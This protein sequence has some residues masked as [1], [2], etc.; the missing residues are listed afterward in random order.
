MP[1]KR[2]KSKLKKDDLIQKVIEM[3]LVECKSTRNILKYLEGIGLKS[4][5]QYQYL[6]WAREQI[7]E[8]FDATTPEAIN[9][10]IGQYESVMEE[11]LKEKNYRMW[12]DMNKELNKLKGLYTE[13]VEVKGDLSI[14]GIDVNIIKDKKDLDE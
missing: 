14:N 3:R 12:N 8:Q 6:K 10:A 5:Q 4:T 9:E 7:A 1:D 2:H 11:V 13:R